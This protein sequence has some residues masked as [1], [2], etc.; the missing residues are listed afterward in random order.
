[1]AQ[2][3]MLRAEVHAR[4]LRASQNVKRAEVFVESNKFKA[5]SQNLASSI[6]MRLA[7]LRLLIGGHLHINILPCVGLSITHFLLR[8]VDLDFDLP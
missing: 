8:F 7:G 2:K 1:M 6:Q 5:V 4:A 3:P